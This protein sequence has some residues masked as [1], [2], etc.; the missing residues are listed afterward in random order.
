MQ[1]FVPP[2]YVGDDDGGERV[3]FRDQNIDNVSKRKM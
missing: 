1:L 3:V 2:I